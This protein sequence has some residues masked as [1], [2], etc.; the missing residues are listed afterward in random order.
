M[1]DPSQVAERPP[2]ASSYLG[3]GYPLQ[4]AIGGTVNAVLQCVIA[5]GV[6]VTPSQNAAVTTLTNSLLVLAA[7]AIATAR[8]ATP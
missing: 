3:I 5:F 6:H 2:S 1:Q 8:H 4:A 7:V